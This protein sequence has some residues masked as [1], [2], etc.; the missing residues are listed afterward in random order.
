M[1]SYIFKIFMG[2]KIAVKCVSA[3]EHLSALLRT[4]GI[5]LLL[6][7]LLREDAISDAKSFLV[8]WEF[9]LPV[10]SCVKCLY[11]TDSFSGSA[12]ELYNID[13]LMVAFSGYRL[14]KLLL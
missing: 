7:F 1:K 11:L 6:L 8:L 4:T 13:Y 5:I 2:Q 3:A 14:I 10:F 12:Q 9:H